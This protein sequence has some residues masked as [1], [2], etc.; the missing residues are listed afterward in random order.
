MSAGS[1]ACAWDVRVIT[2]D[3]VVRA[4][5]AELTGVE[6]AI[7]FWKL[8][9]WDLGTDFQ[10]RSLANLLQ[11]VSIPAGRDRDFA[12]SRRGHRCRTFSVPSRSL[13]T[14]LRLWRHFSGLG[15][16]LRTP[17]FFLNQTPRP[18]RRPPRIPLGVCSPPAIVAVCW[19]A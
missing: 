18:T 3:I 10:S 17:T 9:R 12:C 14:D 2:F 11:E 13:P 7:A 4:E 6:S 19:A 5:K 1:A 8:K 15:C 16:H